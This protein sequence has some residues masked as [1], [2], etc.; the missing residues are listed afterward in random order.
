MV[1]TDGAVRWATLGVIAAGLVMGL[2]ACGNVVAGTGGHAKPAAAKKETSATKALSGIN[3]G[4]PMI[5]ADSTQHVLLCREIPNLTRMTYTRTA[6]PPTHVRE[7]LP[8]GFAVRNPVTV[9]QLASILCGLPRIPSFAMSCPNLAGDTYH[10]YFDAPGTAIPAVKIEL[11]GCRVVTGLG[12][13]RSWAAST[14]LAQALSH[15][16][17]NPLKGVSSP[18]P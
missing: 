12:P 2:A 16:L 7:V 10:L 1:K 14:K 13:A 17:G 8:T 3:P 6:W 4:G 11:S 18:L 5:P 9:R 15:G